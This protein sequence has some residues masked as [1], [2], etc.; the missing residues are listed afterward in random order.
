MM[1]GACLGM[2]ALIGTFDAAGK[3]LAGSSL[4]TSVNS[5]VVSQT[6]RKSEGEGEGHGEI[7]VRAERERRR[8]AFFKVSTLSD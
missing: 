1:A 8:Q 5:A 4:P 6:L 3:S 2:A 7:D